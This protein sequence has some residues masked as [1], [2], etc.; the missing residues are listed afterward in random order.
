MK[1]AWLS[2]FLVAG[3]QLPVSAAPEDKETTERVSYTDR[4]ERDAA[5]DDAA[6]TDGWVELADPTP[7]S[8]RRTFITVDGE[9]GPYTRL[10]IVADSGSPK[11]ERVR[12]HFA[13]GTERVVKL[14]KQ[15]AKRPTYV[16][17]GGPRQIER[18]VVDSVG[19]KRATYS[20]HG[21]HVR[22]AIATR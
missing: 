11:I 2:A 16:D 8:H 18:L 6:D 21:E 9:A 13:D 14:G 3:F 20:V 15:L 19:P 10:K 22:G 4:A 12:I 17:L 7:A 5:R 1:T